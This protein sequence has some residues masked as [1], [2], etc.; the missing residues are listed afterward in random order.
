MNKRKKI[1]VI[2]AGAIG[3]THI[4]V[5]QRS[6]GAALASIVDP[7]PAARLLAETAA[8]PWYADYRHMLDAAPPDG[9]IVATPNATHA[10][11]GI[12]CMERGIPVLVEK[13]VADTL[14]GAHRL[15]AG[16]LATGVPLLVGHHRRH[17]PI[18]RRA[19][20]I[21]QAGHLGQP[22]SATV[23][24]TF[25]KPDGYFDMTWRRQAGG[26]PVLINMIHDIDM[27]LFLFGEI[28]SIQAMS[29]NAV[30][31]F[32][33]EDSA[34]VLMRFRNGALGT[35]TV[36]DSASA[37]WNWDL[38]AGE[39]AHYPRQNENTHFLTGTEG[40]L[41][42]PGLDLWSYRER[43]GWH[44]PL[45]RERTTP[46]T[47]NPYDE[48]MRHFAAVIDGSE[49]PLCSGMDGIRT[50]QATLAVHQAAASGLPVSLRS[51][52]TN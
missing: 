23:M 6:A 45:T 11:V 21:V 36:S 24:A 12:S 50:L 46:H 41:T 4:E 25:R 28:D 42:L 52:A 34:A 49:E 38:C 51:E 2:G 26:G 43:R 27:L 5:L 10:E 44:D 37:P 32:A 14:D 19:R 35:I 7:S 13:P 1:T 40:S 15:A 20:A 8:V 48:Q 30:R 3:R 18:L 9:A 17:N 47:G 39:S 29:S 22:V 33:V 16:S 31:G